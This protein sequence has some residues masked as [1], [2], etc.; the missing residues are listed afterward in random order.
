MIS[1][2]F[3]L[4]GS[5]PLARCYLRL[6][7]SLPKPPERESFKLSL[8][9]NRAL[10]LEARGG[11]SGA[12]SLLRS[13]V[14]RA[15]RTGRIRIAA[16]GAASLALSMARRGDVA[17]AASYVE[18]ANRSYSAHHSDEDLRL[19]NLTR[20]LIEAKRG[21]P[22]AAV[23]RIVCALPPGAAARSARERV[24]GLL[25]LAELS[26]SQ[27]A[28]DRAREALD[29]AAAMREALARFG[30]QRL[31]WLRL[32]RE[33]H[34]RSGNRAEARGFLE[35]AERLKRRLGM[36]LQYD[37]LDHAKADTPFV[38]RETVTRLVPTSE[39]GASAECPAETFI[40]RDPR[41]A[42]VLAGAQRAAR[43][44]LPILIEGES[45]T[46][47]D[48]VARLIHQWS[49]RRR[50]PF[51]PVNVAAL[52]SELFESMV[53]GHAR[54]AFTGAVERRIGLVAAAGRGTLFLDE[55]GDLS[56]AVQAK[57]LRLID[58]R[59][60]IA[61]GETRPRRCEARIVAATNRD[62][63]ADCAS[64]RLRADLYYRIATVVVRIP[65]LRERP[66][67]IVCLAR[68]FADHLH[69]LHGLGPLKLDEGAI[70]VLSDYAWPGNVR[71]LES[72][73]LRA[74]LGASGGVIRACNLSGAL[75]VRAARNGRFTEGDL[76][77]RLASFE[78]TEI[79][80][81]LDACGGNRSH[82][83]RALGLKRTT[84]LS[85]MRRLDIDW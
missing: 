26:L 34:I 84:L 39:D 50:E 58:R 83:A 13:V 53:F 80:T 40:S 49:Q 55:I 20:A 22:D 42:E 46:G 81:A 56:P 2:V 7:A 43:L 59:E 10:I 5:L 73:I 21:S 71:E 8:L 17:T 33:F 72:E 45:G 23:D 25:L 29:A 61:L 69:R 74:A 38:V 4:K 31:D 44:A 41:T 36:E 64:G 66:G 85:A 65:P 19:V 32:E 79:L 14:D 35:T 12:C 18:L 67:D 76:S 16:K 63:K 57:L 54:G 28:L 77:A 75:L 82:A 37:S 3:L 1:S 52:P 70:A 9:I 68:H 27:G 48:I 78:R 6:A 60:Y 62:L 11:A 47:K 30:P 51:V 15:L 24:I